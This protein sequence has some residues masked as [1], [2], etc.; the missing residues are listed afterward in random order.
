MNNIYVASVLNS[1]SEDLATPAGVLVPGQ[2]AYI[3]FNL[4]VFNVAFDWLGAFENGLKAF[5]FTGEE[6]RKEFAYPAIVKVQALA[7]GYGKDLFSSALWNIDVSKFLLA[8]VRSE[9]LATKLSLYN[10]SWQQVV[11]KL[12]A[13]TAVVQ[14]GM[15]NEASAALLTVEQDLFLTTERL[16]RWSTMCKAS[17]AIKQVEVD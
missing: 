2:T 4:D 7:A 8:S 10:T 6:I 12:N 1:A 5:S 13:I 14:L 9:I 16:G 3:F 17:D 15:L 11:Y